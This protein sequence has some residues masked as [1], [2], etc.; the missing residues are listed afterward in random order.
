LDTVKHLSDPVINKITHENAL[1]LFNFDAFGKMGGRDKCTVGALQKI[2]EHVDTS[3][4]SYG[5]PAPLPPGEIRR[6]VTS[7]D[8][9]KMF[10]DVA[11][12]DGIEEAA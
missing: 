3:P 9:T 2:A 11:S 12:R 1:R 6:R 4:K 8:I 5:G 10:R 7:G